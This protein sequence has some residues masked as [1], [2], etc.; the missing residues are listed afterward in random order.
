MAR[1]KKKKKHSR[2]GKSTENET[3]LTCYCMEEN[4]GYWEMDSLTSGL[5]QISTLSNENREMEVA[6][7]LLRVVTLSI[8]RRI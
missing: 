4:G 6:S 5:M 8:I 3:V 1:T 7:L 2:Y